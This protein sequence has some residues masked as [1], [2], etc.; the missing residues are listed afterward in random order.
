M[1]ALMLLLLQLLLLLP[2]SS[3]SQVVGGRDRAA[4]LPTVSCMPCTVSYIQLE[5]YGP[6]DD[7]HVVVHYMMCSV[8]IRAR[9]P[10]TFLHA[11]TRRESSVR[12]HIQS[13]RSCANRAE[14]SDKNALDASIMQI[15]IGAL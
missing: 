14:S 10:S 15:A 2:L 11:C 8:C 9:E 12:C 5:E 3:E 4:D 6:T 13:R 1:H 7:L